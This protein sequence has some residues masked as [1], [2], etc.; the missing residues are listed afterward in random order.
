MLLLISLW[1]RCLDSGNKG[2]NIS[3]GLKSQH[4]DMLLMKFF[5]L[6]NRKDVF[7][8]QV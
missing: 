2:I 4:V 7:I 5:K 1:L 8:K 3:F 6:L